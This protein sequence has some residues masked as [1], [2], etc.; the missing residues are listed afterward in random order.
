MNSQ[1]TPFA[2]LTLMTL[3]L[4]LTTLYI[5]VCLITEQI[6]EVHS[7]FQDF[8]KYVAYIETAIKSSE[9][10]FLYY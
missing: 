4:A 1:I 3:P 7:D 6:L 8:E 10:Y 5:F 9:I 2:L